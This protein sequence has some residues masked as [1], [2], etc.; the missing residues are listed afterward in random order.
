MLTPHPGEFAPA[1][2]RRRGPPTT[3]SGWRALPTLP[4]DSARSS[5]SRARGTV[6]CAPDGRRRGLAVANAA[7]ATAGSGDVLAGLIGALL[8]QGAAP[9]EA[10]CLGVYLHARSGRATRR[11]GWATSGVLASDLRH[12]IP[13]AR[14]E[15]AALG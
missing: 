14:H 7:L 10:A 9:F 5:C 12:E 13:L 11:S 6:V 3:T 2:R 15:L 8:A 1:D 4:S